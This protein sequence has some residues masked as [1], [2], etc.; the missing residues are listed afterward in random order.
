[1]EQWWI[2]GSH[3]RTAEDWLKRLDA[4]RAPL[5]QRFTRAHGAQQAAL[6]LQRWRMFYQAVAELFGYSCGRE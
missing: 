6:G 4:A 2:D 3:A 1:L 5:M